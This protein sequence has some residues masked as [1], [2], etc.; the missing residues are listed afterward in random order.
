MFR[1]KFA[2]VLAAVVAIALSG[3]ASGDIARPDVKLVRLAAHDSF[4]ISDE[5]IAEFESESGYQLE[6]V[7]LG[8]TGSLT[9]QLILTKDAPITDAFYGIDNTFLPSAEA[10]ELVV[11]EATAINYGD[12]CFN[13]DI[14]WFEDAGI[15]PPANWRELVDPAYRS[16]TVISNPL[17]SS[18]GLA[19]LA[20]TFAGFETDAEVF[21]YWRQLRDNGV[22]VAA[23]WDDAYF[24]DFTRY[25]GDRPVV[26]SYAAS[27]SAEVNA[28]GTAGSAALLDECFR[29]TEYAGV[30]ANSANP[31]G[32]EAL[33]EFLA[34]ESFQASVAENMYVYPMLSEV[35]LPESWQQFAPAARNVIGED[36]DIAAERDRW[37]DD[38]SSV[39]DN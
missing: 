39:F 9:N 23:S 37:L 8:D 27:P 21:E 38:W 5:L 2:V 36:L 29:Q 4:V 25:G 14:A 10:A 1:A 28:D 18:P 12:V 13:Y 11:G 20:S 30:L 6:V 19:F 7:R 33:V 17:L 35:V 16:L 32:A 34:G 24:V 22:R 15:T 31:V 3:C 26:L